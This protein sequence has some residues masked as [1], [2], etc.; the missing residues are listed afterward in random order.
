MKHS[1]AAAWRYNPWKGYKKPVRLSCHL[2]ACLIDQHIKVAAIFSIREGQG[3]QALGV[4]TGCQYTFVQGRLGPAGRRLE[5]QELVAFGTHEVEDFVHGVHTGL[6]LILLRGQA[7][8]QTRGLTDRVADTPA[9][10]LSSHSLQR[11]RRGLCACG[12]G[13]AL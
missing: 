11:Q 10:R 1:G 7:E 13:S 3:G 8:G 6:D 12:G 5:V 2:Y 4:T 9:P